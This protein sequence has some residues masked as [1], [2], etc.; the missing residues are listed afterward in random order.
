[1]LFVVAHV[2]DPGISLRFCLEFLAAQLGC[3]HKPP[4]FLPH[5]QWV[6]WEAPSVVSGILSEDQR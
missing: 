2:A 6:Q 3:T 4:R 1:M 5:E